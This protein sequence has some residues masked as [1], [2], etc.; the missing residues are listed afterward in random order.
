[1]NRKSRTATDKA[2]LREW[3][4]SNSITLPRKLYLD[5]EA[6]SRRQGTTVHRLALRLLK[7]ELGLK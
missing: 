6:E 7:D 1:M 2:N 3:L 4:P 5:L